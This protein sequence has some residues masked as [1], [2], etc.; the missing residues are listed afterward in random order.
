MGQI[1]QWN[2]AEIAALNPGRSLPALPIRVVCRSDGSGT[3]YNFTDYLS[4]ASP[5]WRTRFGAASKHPWPPTFIMAKGSSEVSV[6]VRNTSGAIGY[7]DY[8]Y[9]IEDGLV[10]VQVRNAAGYFVAAS[11]EGFRKAVVNSRWFT[12]GDFS[13]T[14]TDL[15]GESS[16]PITM[17]TFVAVPRIAR[18][19]ARAMQMLRFFVWAFVKGD[20]LASQSKFVPLPE[21]VQAKA[22]RELASVLGSKGDLIG[23]DALGGLKN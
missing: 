10:G 16:W 8:N 23:I 2:A 1:S 4:K 19:S 7:I 22:F 6:A 13:Q 12:H 11:I 18:D 5:E 3:T 21:K 9:V 15:A 20:V 14:L 17:G